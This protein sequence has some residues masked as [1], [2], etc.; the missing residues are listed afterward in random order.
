MELVPNTDEDPRLRFG[1]GY[2][3]LLQ[4]WAQ[5][6]VP[7]PE[8]K[9]AAG[10]IW[11]SHSPPSTA[12]RGSVPPSAGIAPSSDD[13]AADW[14][15]EIRT[16]LLG[17][18]QAKVDIA[19]LA[20]GQPTRLTHAPI[21]RRW[22]FEGKCYGGTPGR[23]ADAGP[24]LVQQVG[25][26]LDTFNPRARISSRP[27][28]HVDWARTLALGPRWPVSEYVLNTSGVGIALDRAITGFDGVIIEAKS[29]RQDLCAPLLQL[30]VYRSALRRSSRTKRYL[31]WGIVEDQ[32]A[33]VSEPALAELARLARRQ[34]DDVWILCRA[35]DI[36]R[37]AAQLGWA[38]APSPSPPG[39]PAAAAP[40][41]AG[42][43]LVSRAWSARLAG[44][45]ELRRAVGVPA[46]AADP[47]NQGR[48]P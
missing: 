31:L 47:R 11:P 19:A 46:A 43:D 6:R 3:V 20:A 39:R 37:C 15:R 27:E 17:R 38:G 28:G 25:L 8:P 4:A 12:M 7:S 21:R 13:A 5:G 44:G 24:W 2:F 18:L 22:L 42:A 41:R 30:K 16:F 48:L 9:G 45:L 33:S 14:A 23:L 1:V 40:E 26:L 32:A 35:D 10:P 34:A 29:G 36:P